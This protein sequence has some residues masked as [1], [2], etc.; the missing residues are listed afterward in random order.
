M[1]N[2]SGGVFPTDEGDR[3][4]NFKDRDVISGGLLILCGLAGYFFAYQLENLAVAGLSAAF[5]P[6]F[7]FTVLV[8]CGLI[9]IKQGLK[10]EKKIAFPNLHLAKLLPVVGI[11]V[12][13]VLLME[14]LGFIISTIVFLLSSLYVFG[15]RR[16]KMLA[17]VP[18][19][20][21][22]IVYFLF[23]KAF[24]IVLPGLGEFL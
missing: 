24:M 23:N 6:S 7:L 5:F 12:V 14:Y 8:I 16:K 4:L 13:Y 15:E 18:V 19:M 22:V 21:A 10:R 11:L 17:V 9:L 2:P 3:I 1:P 20:T